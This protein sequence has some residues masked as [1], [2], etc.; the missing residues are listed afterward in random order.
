VRSHNHGSTAFLAY[1]DIETARHK[2]YQLL[3]DRAR[4][5]WRERYGP[6]IEQNTKNNRQEQVIAQTFNRKVA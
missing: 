3:G 1:K 4:Q 6:Q 5:G 2:M